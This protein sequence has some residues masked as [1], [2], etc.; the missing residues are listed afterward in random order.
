VERK[1]IQLVQRRP[2]GPYT[3]VPGGVAEF[4]VPVPGFGG[5]GAVYDYSPAYWPNI[6]FDEGTWALG[7][8]TVWWWDGAQ[9]LGAFDFV[10]SGLFVWDGYCYFRSL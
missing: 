1:R 8:W 5:G 6:G 2:G 9:W 4:F 10:Y 3:S 7:G